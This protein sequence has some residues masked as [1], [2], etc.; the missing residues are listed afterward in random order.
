MSVRA[1]YMCREVATIT[2]E[3][4]RWVPIVDICA[5]FQHKPKGPHIPPLCCSQQLHFLQLSVLKARLEWTPS[6]FLCCQTSFMA[7]ASRMQLAAAI[8]AARLTYGTSTQLGSRTAYEYCTSRDCWR[9]VNPTLQL[10]KP[11]E[12][13]KKNS[14][15]R[16]RYE[17]PRPA[18]ARAGQKQ[19]EAQN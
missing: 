3:A 1:N 18:P 13:L 10:E 19:P 6:T 15:V 9:A 7:H 8:L 16:Y 4:H 5:P 2:S 12:T 11:G 17:Y 14:T